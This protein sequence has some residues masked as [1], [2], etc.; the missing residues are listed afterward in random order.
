M[1]ALTTSTFALTTS[2]YIPM[3]QLNF[4]HGRLMQQMKCD[5]MSVK[6]MLPYIVIFR[7]GTVQTFA[8][9][10]LLLLFQQRGRFNMSHIMRKLDFRLCENKGA[11]QLHSIGIMM[12]HLT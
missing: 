2:P 7:V 9:C 11:D 8:N 5:E 12:P 4:L 1:F 10:L 6:P 3:M